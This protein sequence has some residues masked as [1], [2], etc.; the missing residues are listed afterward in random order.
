MI[1]LGIRVRAVD[2]EVAYAR[3]EPIL[4]AGFEEVADGEHIE[5]VVYGEDRQINV[6]GAG[7]G[8]PRS[9]SPTAGRPPG[10]STWRR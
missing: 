7:L 4:A 1:R 9:R 3:L 5:F 6:P 2:A 8:V 10:T